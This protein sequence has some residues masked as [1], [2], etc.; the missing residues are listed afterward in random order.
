MQFVNFSGEVMEGQNRVRVEVERVE[1]GGWTM[2]NR[3][4]VG[5]E[6]LVV[7]GVLVTG[8][9]NPRIFN[10]RSRTMHLRNCYLSHSHSSTKFILIT[11]R[12]TTQTKI[13]LP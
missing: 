3:H 11:L 7:F 13:Y 8:S 6:N 5:L 4:G 10:I 2:N 9:V 1:Q 12:E